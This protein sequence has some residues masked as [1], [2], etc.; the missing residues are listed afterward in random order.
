MS[1]FLHKYAGLIA[2]L[3]LSFAMV[4][5]LGE[6]LWTFDHR[7]IALGVSEFAGFAVIWPV[8]VNMVFEMKEEL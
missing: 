5:G 1:N 3:L 8:L 6:I 7:G 4:G 2:T